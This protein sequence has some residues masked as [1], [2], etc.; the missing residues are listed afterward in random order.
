MAAVHLRVSGKITRRDLPARGQL[1][2]SHPAHDLPH[3][4]IDLG[5]HAGL[6]GLSKWRA[7]SKARKH[8]RRLN[9]NGGS[10]RR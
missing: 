7:A 9:G 4:A 2:I 1:E 5:V 10:N 3:R 8:R 6:Y